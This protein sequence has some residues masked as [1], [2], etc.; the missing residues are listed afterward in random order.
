MHRNTKILPFLS[1]VLLLTCLVSCKGSGHGSDSTTAPPAT[2]THEYAEAV[3]PPT[4]SA[5]GYTVHSCLHCDDYYTDTPVPTLPH[6]YMEEITAPTCFAGGYTKYTCSVCGDS[7]TDALTAKLEHI[8]VEEIVP[9]TCTEQGYTKHVCYHCGDSYQDTPTPA[10]GHYYHSQVVAPTGT[11]KGYTLHTCTRCG[12]SYRDTYTDPVNRDIIVQFNTDGGIM[13]EEPRIVYLYQTGTQVTLP[14]PTKEGHVFRGWY[15]DPADES[16][17]VSDGI[18]SIAEDTWLTAAWSSISV[19]VTLNLGEG[20]A[21]LSYNH[22][23]FTW[24]E[25]LGALPTPQAL[26]GYTFDGYYDGDTRVSTDTISRYTE[27][28]SLIARFLP[29]RATG[30]EGKDTG[31]GY[32]WAVYADGTL[33][34]SLTASADGKQNA[35]TI[36]DGTFRGMEEI[37]AVELPEHI[38]DIGNHAFADCVNLKEIFVPGSATV[39]RSSVFEGCTALEHVVLGNGISVINQD[40]FKGCTSLTSLTVPT[41]LLQIYSPF[42]GCAALRQIRYEGTEFQWSVIVKDPAAQ[43]T[44]SAPEIQYVYQVEYPRD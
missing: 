30:Q 20:G 39:I 28:V 40:A 23:V 15:I 37:V 29:P 8:R 22:R 12:H 6:S 4:C 43:A 1:I 24:G 41:S 14:V 25:P 18:W 9:P 5:E 38:T 11:E 27:P 33:R 2:H 34:F 7:Y 19:D 17:L 10:I 16:T 36:A 3:I 44:F 13:P 21:S 32:D 31:N 26:F 35:F 42:E